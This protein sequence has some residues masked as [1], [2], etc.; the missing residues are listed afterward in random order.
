VPLT[1]VVLALFGCGAIGGAA[2]GFSAARVKTA[3]A[4][5]TPPADYLQARGR[6]AVL[7][8]EGFSSH[9]NGSAVEGPG[10]PPG[11]L[12]TEFSYRGESSDGRPK[13]YT[14]GAT[15]AS[16][17][18]LAGL[19][20]QQVAGLPSPVRPGHCQLDVRIAGIPISYRIAAATRSATC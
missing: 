20:A 15:H 2:T 8:V 9:W 17:T 14:S 7:L 6:A 12:V 4:A 13:P 11:A 16:L 18:R 1:P 5:A 10:A 19:M 3:P